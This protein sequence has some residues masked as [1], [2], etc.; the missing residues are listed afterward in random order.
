MVRSISIFSQGGDKGRKTTV[1]SLASFLS[2]SQH[3]NR[4]SPYATNVLIAKPDSLPPCPVALA[5]FLTKRPSSDF[6][7]STNSGSRNNLVQ[8]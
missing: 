8:H 1:R 5:S 3:V 4:C 2:S 7:F 6:D